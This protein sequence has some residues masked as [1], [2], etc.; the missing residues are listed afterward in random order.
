M[1][2]IGVLDTYCDGKKKIRFINE[3]RVTIRQKIYYVS[4]YIIILGGISV[5]HLILAVASPLGDTFILGTQRV[6]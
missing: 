6:G 5:Y 1:F 3:L 2:V 4:L